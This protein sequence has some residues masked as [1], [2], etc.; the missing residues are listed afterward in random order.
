MHRLMRVIGIAATVCAGLAGAPAV[1][2]AQ[3]NGQISAT[4]CPADREF[5][6]QCLGAAFFGTYE[7]AAANCRGRVMTMPEMLAFKMVNKAAAGIECTSAFEAAGGALWCVGPGGQISGKTLQ[8]QA[9]G[10]STMKAMFR[11]SPGAR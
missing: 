5:Y 4:S 10:L 7:Y 11:C 2:S 3:V 1:S 6:G 9:Q 8:N